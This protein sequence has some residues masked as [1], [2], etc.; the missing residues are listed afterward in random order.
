MNL[1]NVTVDPAGRSFAPD[2]VFNSFS[3]GPTPV[4]P[5]DEPPPPP[6]VLP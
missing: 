1:T 4:R 6:T 3:L 5:K 2:F